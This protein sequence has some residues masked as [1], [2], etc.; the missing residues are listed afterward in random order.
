MNVQRGL[1]K[2][3]ISGSWY[4]MRLRSSKYAQPSS[5]RGQYHG[6]VPDGLLRKG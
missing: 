5:D 1:Q 3:R 6:I 4:V 2:T